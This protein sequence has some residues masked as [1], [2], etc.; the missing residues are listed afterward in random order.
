MVNVG[1]K[2]HVIT[3]FIGVL[4]VLQELTLDDVSFRSRNVMDM[5][6]PAGQMGNRQ[7]AIFCEHNGAG[8]VFG[9]PDI[10]RDQTIRKVTMRKIP[11]IPT[12]KFIF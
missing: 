5:N 4:P 6:P 7:I 11:I 12:C 10:R 1:H 2:C 3:H 9:Y 8:V